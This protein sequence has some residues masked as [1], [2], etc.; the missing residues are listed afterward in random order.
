[1]GSIRE[2]LHDAIDLL[3]DEETR[4]VLALVQLLQKRRGVSPGLQRLA[5]DPTFSVP[6]AGV[7][8][9]PAVEPV[10]GQGDLPPCSWWMTAGDHCWS[11]S[12][13]GATARIDED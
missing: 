6:A 9:F 13:R 1:M 8:G 5:A 2:S 10:E 7:M 3:S 4:Q 11:R 12:R